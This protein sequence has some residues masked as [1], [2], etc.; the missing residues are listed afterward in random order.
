MNFIS[1]FYCHRAT[2]PIHNFGLH[3][4]DFIG[5]VDRNLKLNTYLGGYDLKNQQFLLGIKNHL[6]ADEIWHNHT[7]FKAKTR[8]IKE[9][10]KQ[11]GISDKPYRPF[12]MTH[13]ML[14]I[15]LDRAIIRYEKQVAEDMYLSLE[16]CDDVFLN[17][18]FKDADISKK[19]MRFFNNFRTKRYAL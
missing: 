5:I 13:V 8:L 6:K 12:F 9:V 14:E 19:F 3:F 1:H 7:F 2:S 17:T 15:L 18:L 4:P 11:Y 10:L 16:K